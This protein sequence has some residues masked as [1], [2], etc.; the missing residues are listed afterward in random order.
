MDSGLSNVGI[1][2]FLIFIGVPFLILISIVVIKKFK[3]KR[4][5]GKAK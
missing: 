4:T 2:I 5:T 1:F 3:V